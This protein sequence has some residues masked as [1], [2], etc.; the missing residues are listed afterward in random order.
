[1]NTSPH[2]LGI[3]A[4]RAPITDYWHST[5]VP[6][7]VA[8]RAVVLQPVHDGE[9]HNIRRQRRNPNFFAEDKINA[10]NS[11]FSESKSVLGNTIRPVDI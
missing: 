4:D 7:L 8:V 9:V 1:M 2:P 5:M 11:H 10:A 6:L 3:G